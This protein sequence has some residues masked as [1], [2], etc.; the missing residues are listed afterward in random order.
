MQAFNCPHCGGSIHVTKAS[1]QSTLANWSEAITFNAAA[2]GGVANDFSEWT[3]TIPTR[4]PTASGDVVVPLAQAAITGFVF[5]LTSGA[6]AYVQ[7]W[8]AWV[9]VAV[10]SGVFA[11][12]WMW[13][14]ADH[15]SL[16][17]VT[18]TIIGR[19]LD[20][21]GQVGQPAASETVRVEV[22]EHHNE[23]GDTSN[24]DSMRFFELPATRSALRHFAREALN[25][26]ELSE[27]A[28]AGKGRPISGPRFRNLRDS[29]IEA[30][31]LR[32][33]SESDHR[34][35]AAVTRKGAEFF[36]AVVK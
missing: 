34:Q 3:R 11:L 2:P 21:D 19:D 30:G 4:A 32:W 15:R 5:G 33:A 17:R 14:L 18:E 24:V 35:G 16:L 12:A 31:Y 29:L 22:V 8:P 25:G 28:M 1:P 6:I 27:R 20:G 13:L 10:G 7:A 26:V 9:P 36:Q 23:A